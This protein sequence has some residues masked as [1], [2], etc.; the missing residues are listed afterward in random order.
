MAEI[1]LSGGLA[2]DTLA[3]LASAAFLRTTS[4]DAA[5]HAYLAGGPPG[6]EDGT[7][8]TVDLTL[9]KVRALRYGENPHQTGTLYTW[10]EGP[11]VI[12]AQLVHG[13]E[14]SYN[15]YLDIYAGA[16][17]V[18]DFDSPAVSIIKHTNPSGVA[19]ADS[20]LRAYKRAFETDKV[21]AFGGIVACN[22]EVDARTA[23]EIVQVFT[24]IVVAPSFSEAALGVL[25]KRKNLRVIRWP[26]MREMERGGP[27]FSSLGAAFL[28]QVTAPAGEETW[29]SP[30]ER[31]PTRD[32]WA[33]LRFAW[34]VVSCVKSNA[35]VVAREER[36]LGIGAGQQSRVG[37]VRIAVQNAGRKAKDAVLA[38]DGFFP[39]PDSVETAADAGISAIIQ[40]GGSIKDRE[41]VRA[42]D[43]H[44]IAMVI[45]NT[46][47]FLH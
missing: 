3:S 34:K 4:Y 41:I 17:I 5:I 20:P 10:R 46:R 11:S 45:T 1:D 43:D 21:S 6:K 16:I 37:S 29:T 22:R 24:E 32:E 14:M 19:V 36:T 12:D 30:T 44:G 7:A 9:R 18:S 2:G 23:A 25:T 8:S 33:D 28:G 27:E 42:A 31:G 38:S 39:F 13:P 35:I 47:A 40:P 26:T 15:N